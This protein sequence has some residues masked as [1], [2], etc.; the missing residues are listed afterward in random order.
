MVLYVCDFLECVSSPMR[1]AS[2][3]CVCTVLCVIPI[4]LDLMFVFLG[5]AS[6]RPPCLLPRTSCEQTQGDVHMFVCVCVCV[7]SP[8]VKL[9]SVC[10][11]DPNAHPQ[12]KEK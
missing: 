1:R 8:I 12:S 5:D 11:C 6:P 4:I 3:L 9:S 7:H 2:S 10:E